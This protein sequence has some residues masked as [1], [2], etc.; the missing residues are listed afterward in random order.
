MI[1]DE[2]S[3]H[4]FGVYEGLQTLAL[5]PPS[6]K[7]PIILFTGLNGA[8]KTTILEALQVGLFGA[9][10]LCLAD[11]SY[12]EYMARAINKRS[13]WGQAGVTICFRRM[14]N[15]QEISYRLS[16]LFKRTGKN[17]KESLE[18]YRND[19]YDRAITEH[20]P[21]FVDEIIPASISSFFFF[22]GERVESYAAPDSARELI[23][24][25]IHNLL[26]LDIVNRLDHDLKILLRRR[27][28]EKLQDSQ[29]S[30]LSEKEQS[31]H[32]LRK[33]I[34]ELVNARAA[35]RARKIDPLERKLGELDQEYKKMGGDL[36]E[37]RSSIEKKLLLAEH[38]GQS[39]EKKMHE[40]AAG[41]LPLLLVKELLGKLE[42]YAQR[43]E[44]AYSL[45]ATI[46]A[47]KKRDKDML[48]HFQAI[49]KDKNS[50]QALK[51]FCASDIKDR[52]A[53][54][55]EYEKHTHL[56]AKDFV[57][58]NL[59]EVDKQIK[60]F[61]LDATDAIADYQEVRGEIENLKNKLAAVPSSDTVAGILKERDE[62]QAKLVGCQIEHQKISQDISHKKAEESQLAQ[63]VEAMWK[64]V[65]E[66]EFAQR[67]VERY[68][69]RIKNAKKKLEK[70]RSAVL[71]KNIRR[72]ETFVL[73]CYQ[74][75]LR[76]KSLIE[77]LE[78]D[79]HSF[80]ISL[81]GK[82]GSPLE[83]EQLSAGER[84]L[85]AIALLWGLG[86]ASS[87][88]LPIAI[89]TPLGRLDSTHREKLIDN[90]FSQASHQVLLFSTDEEISGEY[91]KRLQ[92]WIGKQYQLNYDDAAGSTTV[93]E[94]LQ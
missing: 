30:S 51:S 8:G 32:A 93:S 9:N 27:Q 20:W 58:M 11:Q 68:I 34:Q 47:L 64:E 36:L 33:E 71:A 67:S 76:K 85:L 80:R 48:G 92:P 79:P 73:E 81:T 7:H 89:D 29:K 94:T 82:N 37:N 1:L 78:I 75:L 4:D 6:A 18:V 52:T 22:D 61:A 10:A 65:A 13:Q 86:R 28:A 69:D 70:F 55:K 5:T 44:K 53:K 15:G 49:V 26:G 54:L 66:V 74:L 39:M 17:I 57:D 19:E 88:P 63:L 72:M 46:A 59:G 50:M 40:L 45:K 84:Q 25:G 21:Q 16:R 2:I 91:L 24:D 31:L 77:N 56:D 43:C 83:A 12:Q 23:H 38:R 42:D 41:Q 62:I 3:L 87:K 90:Y 35:L 14:E 60:E